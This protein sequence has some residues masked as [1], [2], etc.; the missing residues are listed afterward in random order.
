LQERDADERSQEGDFFC[1]YCE[2]SVDETEWDHSTKDMC[3]ACSSKKKRRPPG[4]EVSS[5][6]AMLM[7]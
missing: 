1:V 3:D 7:F 4:E 2:K 6:S 5:C